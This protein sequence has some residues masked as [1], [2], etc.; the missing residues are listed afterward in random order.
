MIIGVGGVGSWA[1]EAFARSGVG[2]VTLVDFDEVCI[3]NANRQMHALQ[4]MVGRKKA[5]VMAERL[6]KIN[7]QAQ[8]DAIVEFYN[9]ENS[10]RILSQKPDYVIDCIDNITAKTHL[11]ATCKKLGIKV[12]TAGGAGARMDPSFIRVADLSETHSDQFLHQVRKVLRQE[13][14][15][16]EGPWGIKTVFSVEEIINP[17]E[18][19]YDEGKGF[20]CVCPQGQN[21]MH[22]CDRRPVIWG[23][24]SFVTGA[25]GFQL[26]SIV[27][28]EIVGHQS[29]MKTK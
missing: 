5:E 24:A 11:I 13:H 6:R 22:S 4:G 23:N 10:E 12:L 28:Q 3:T 25:F 19:H 9:Q 21:N 20:K 1:S 26:A 18:L 7:P 8:I 15:F 27:V 2:H 29:V 16:G 17:Y 14:G